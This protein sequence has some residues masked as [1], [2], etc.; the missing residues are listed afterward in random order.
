MTYSTAAE[1]NVYFDWKCETFLLG[2][3]K[4]FKDFPALN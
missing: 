1:Q 4:F 3:V 2:Y